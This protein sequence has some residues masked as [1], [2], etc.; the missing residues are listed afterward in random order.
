[1][2]SALKSIVAALRSAQSA[3]SKPLTVLPG[4]AKVYSADP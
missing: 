1:V 4:L 3:A 2:K